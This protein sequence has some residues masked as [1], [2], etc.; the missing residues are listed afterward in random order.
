M[1]KTIVKLITLPSEA[2]RQADAAAALVTA[3]RVNGFRPINWGLSN[4]HD[5]PVASPCD[6]RLSA[7]AVDTKKRNYP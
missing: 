3:L 6:S 4:R 5:P 7:A 2:S 1:L